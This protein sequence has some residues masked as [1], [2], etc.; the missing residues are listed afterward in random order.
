MNNKA[1]T[2][3]VSLFLVIFLI[4]FRISYKNSGKFRESIW[5]ALI[6]ATVTLS[7]LSV[8]A[9]SSRLSETEGF[10]PPSHSRPA[11]KNTGLFNQPKPQN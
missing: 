6:W 2:V 1:N 7:P 10:I 3:T 9:K 4:G 11:N 5:I 8:Q